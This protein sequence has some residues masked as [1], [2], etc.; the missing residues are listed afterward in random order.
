[1]LWKKKMRDSVIQK[2]NVCN[3]VLPFSALICRFTLQRLLIISKG[4]V[5]SST[6]KLCMAIVH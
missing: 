4:G 5:P 3:F 1:M 2:S 6:L